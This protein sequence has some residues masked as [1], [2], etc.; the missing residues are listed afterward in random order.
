[1]EKSILYAKIAVSQF[2]FFKTQVSGVSRIS[3]RGGGSKFFWKSGGIC[4]ARS[5]IYAARGND[6]DN[7]NDNDNTF[8]EHKYRLQI[9][10]Y[11]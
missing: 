10:L 3:F 6:N 2:F 9:R 4:M 11:I 1:M 8:I 7:D 5:A